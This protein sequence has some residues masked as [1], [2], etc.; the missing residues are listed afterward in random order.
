MT[1]NER[2]KRN[3]PARNE[4]SI[5]ELEQGLLIDREDLETVAAE[6]AE[7]FWRVADRVEILISLRDAAKTELTEIEAEEELRYRASIP[8]DEKVREG[9]VTANVLLHK[10]V[11]AAKERLHKLNAD[12]GRWKAL[13]ESFEQRSYALNH[14]VELHMRKYYGEI[15]RSE[16]DATARRV[17]EARTRRSS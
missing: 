3:E 13:K 17:R 11:K 4:F 10:R 7:L 9:E 8:S 12:L 16:Q 2:V 5:E 14:M 6:H 1:H 15:S